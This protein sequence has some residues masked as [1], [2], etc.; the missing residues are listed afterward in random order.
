ML[1]AYI[2]VT[3]Y[4]QKRSNHKLLEANC[5]DLSCAEHIIVGESYLEG[6]KRGLKEVG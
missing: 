4:L 1:L 2:V 3:K 5:W 6:A